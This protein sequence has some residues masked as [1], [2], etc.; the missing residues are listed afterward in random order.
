MR[1]NDNGKGHDRR[2]RLVSRKTMDKNWKRTFDKNKRMYY[3]ETIACCINVLLLL[4]IPFLPFF[5]DGVKLVMGVI[6]SIITSSLCSVY[7]AHQK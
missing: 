2:P 5:I 3:K 7:V 6:G 4:A 1:F